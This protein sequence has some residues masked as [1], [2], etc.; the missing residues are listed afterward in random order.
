MA[1][2]QSINIAALKDAISNKRIEWQKH[3]LE[4]MA[5]RNV[6]R[7][8]VIDVLLT[9][10]RIEDYPDDTPF[11]SALFFKLIEQKPIH[12]VVAYDYISKWT[13]IITA[14]EPTIEHFETNFKTR[15][16]K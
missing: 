16:E 15:R 4:R 11:P 5:E 1:M 6:L 10:E 3:A 14:Y 8:T 9:G 12:V 7:S 2:A 13:F